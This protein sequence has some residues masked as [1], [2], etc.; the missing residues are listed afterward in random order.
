MRLFGE[1]KKNRMIHIYRCIQR[2]LERQARP[3]NTELPLPLGGGV[4]RLAY[5]CI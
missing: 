4:G 5:I 3:S 1:G 2:S